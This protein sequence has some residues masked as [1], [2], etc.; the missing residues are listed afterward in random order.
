M[1]FVFLLSVSVSQLLYKMGVLFPF[2]RL[3]SRIF[4]AFIDHLEAG[5]QCS[6]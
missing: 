1:F 5:G 4:R 6:L 3:G 2:Y